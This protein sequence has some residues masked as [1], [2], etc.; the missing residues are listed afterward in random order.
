MKVGCTAVTG[1]KL[2]KVTNQVT[3]RT[4]MW[5]LFNLLPAEVAVTVTI[6]EI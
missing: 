5:M 6:L 1:K 2:E 3:L 4:G